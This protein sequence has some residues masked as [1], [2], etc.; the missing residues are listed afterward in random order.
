MKYINDKV[1]ALDADKNELNRKI[2]ELEKKV[3]ISMINEVSDHVKR[4]QELRFEDRQSVADL[5]IREI[6]I[7]NGNIEIYWNC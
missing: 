7:A 6:H 1:V 5:L 3:D 4:L 2:K